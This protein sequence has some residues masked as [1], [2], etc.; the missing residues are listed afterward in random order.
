[1]LLK[2][3]R[4]DASS[5]FT[6]KVHNTS[7]TKEHGSNNFDHRR[8]SS[9]IFPSVLGRGEGYCLLLATAT[10]VAAWRRTSL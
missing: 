9:V 2:F 5:L 6:K 7:A 10:G 8:S 1:M 4:K 3:R